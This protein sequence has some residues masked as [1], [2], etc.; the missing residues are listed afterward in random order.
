MNARKRPIAYCGECDGGYVVERGAGGVGWVQRPCDCRNAALATDRLKRLMRPIPKLHRNAHFDRA[1]IV[2]MPST[3][4][5]RLRTYIKD[6]KN[7]KSE[8]DPGHGLWLAGGPGT[9][10]TA[11]AAMIARM[12]HENGLHATWHNVLKLLWDFQETYEQD[13]PERRVNELIDHIARFDLVVLDDIGIPRGTP[14]ALEALYALLNEL[15]ERERSVVVTTYLTEAQIDE[16]YDLS[17]GSRISEIC[18][19]PLV[20]PG[21]DLRRPHLAPPEVAPVATATR[22]QSLTGLHSGAV[23]E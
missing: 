8:D 12:S 4:K 1:P 19:Q 18:G 13:S 5:T 23:T 3:I 11:A 16:R 22:Q 6:L 17:I 2:D 21:Y 10:K 9:G 15:F 7:T 20:I 14:W